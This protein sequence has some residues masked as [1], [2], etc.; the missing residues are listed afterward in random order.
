M[1]GNVAV[2]TGRA[3]GLVFDMVAALCEAGA[4]VC[5]ASRRHALWLR[6]RFCA[7]LFASRFWQR[8]WMDRNLSRLLLFRQEWLRGAIKSMC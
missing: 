3:R 5:I 1:K 8:S 7:V 4:M 6:R 2:V